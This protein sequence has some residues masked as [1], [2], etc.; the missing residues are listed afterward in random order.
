MEL[1]YPLMINARSFHTRTT[2]HQTNYPKK[3]TTDLLVPT[4]IYKHTQRN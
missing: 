1:I 3:Q 2:K 4:T